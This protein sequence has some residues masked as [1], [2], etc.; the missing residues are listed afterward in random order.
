MP[1]LDKFSFA[2]QI[3]WFCW[4]FLSYYLLIINNFL[5]NILKIIRF[6]AY[7]LA[8][9]SAGAGNAISEELLIQNSYISLLAMNI[10]L[11]QHFTTQLQKIYNNWLQ[12]Q[13]HVV[14]L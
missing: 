1:Q 7:H 13:Q 9:V 14:V 6:R 3:F 10:K 12:I 11:T 2:T 5:P 4:L 8:R